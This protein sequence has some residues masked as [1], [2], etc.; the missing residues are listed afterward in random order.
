MV[1]NNRL[2]SQ[3]GKRMYATCLRLLD[4]SD[5]GNTRTAE[6]GKETLMGWAETGFRKEKYIEV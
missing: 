6:T 3:L 4:R 2:P 5:K 1:C